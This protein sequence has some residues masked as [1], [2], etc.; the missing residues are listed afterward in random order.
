MTKPGRSGRAGL[1]LRRLAPWLIAG[2][3]IA[4]LLRRYSLGAIVA[5]MAH[6]TVWHLLPLALAMEVVSLCLLGY[7]DGLVIRRLAKTPVA[8]VVRARAASSMLE[9]VGYAAGRAGYGVWIARRNV[10]VATTSGILLYLM[11]SD[12][13]AVCLVACASIGL[14]GARV[15]ML[16]QIAAPATALVLLALALLGRYLP[17]NAWLSAWNIVKPRRA[18]AQL[19]LRTAQIAVYVL[20]S[21]LALDTFGLPVPLWAALAYLPVALVVESL[22]I[23][24]AGFGAVQTVWL[25]FTNFAAAERILAFQFLWQLAILFALVSLG[26]LSLRPYLRQI[27]EGAATAHSGK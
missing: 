25:L 23:N 13:T 1:W 11:A 15:P 2:A 27:A 10:S 20:V 4:V 3:V 21:W 5:E 26:L 9:V 7:A 24:V 22:P 17:Q 14:A 6:G 8:D 18:A 16:L 12:L 19:L